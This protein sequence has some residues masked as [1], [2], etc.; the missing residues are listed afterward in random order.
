MKK[1]GQITVFIIIG[2]ILLIITALVFYF[3]KQQAEYKPKKEIIQKLGPV[4]LYM[5]SCIDQLGKEA[6]IKMGQTGGYVYLPKILDKAPAAHIIEDS[7]GMLKVPFWYFNDESYMPSLEEMEYQIGL[8]VNNSFKGCLRDFEPLKKEFAFRDV[9]N[10][11]FKVT[12]AEEDIVIETVFPLKAEAIGRNEV[13]NVEKFNTYI[14]ARLK[15]VYTLAQSIFEEENRRMFL[16]NITLGVM[17][18]SPDIPFTGMEFSCTPEIWNLLNIEK[19]LKEDIAAVAQRIRFRNTNYVPF[20][21]PESVYERFRGLNRDPATGEITNMPREKLP[22][23]AY[24]YFHFFIDATSENFKDLTVSAVY[25]DTWPMNVDARPSEGVLLRAGNSGGFPGILG[26]LC[27]N[28]YHFVYDVYHPVEIIIR[29]PQSFG[30]AG[31]NFKFAMP[32][33]IKSNRAAKIPLQARQFIFPG[34]N[35]G[36][37]SEL[38]SAKIDIR[39]LDSIT[40]E[41]LK[42]ANI[43][44]ECMRYV[45]DLGKTKADSGIYRLRTGY[46]VACPYGTLV[47]KKD[48]YM[49]ARATSPKEGVAKLQ[50]TPLKRFTFNV[51]KIVSLN[52]KEE[53][54]LEDEAVFITIKN[55]KNRF[56]ANL[57]Y[58]DISSG[59]EGVTDNITT[60]ELLDD[61]AEY[62]LEMMIMKGEKYVGGWSGNW[63]VSSEQMYKKKFINFIVY[64][65]VPYPDSDYEIA[66]MLS[67]LPDD[68]KKYPPRFS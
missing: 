11:S 45:C 38:S 23:D 52:N 43:S 50:M 4:E 17:T 10:Y 63:S 19:G 53:R 36:P 16:E 54:L 66:E 37:C 25:L 6:V 47:A 2:V 46:P 27:I 26:F 51:T 59:A 34:I 9:G 61:D 62:E 49:D 41:E 14:P 8:Y 29:D 18:M 20:E 58:P 39:A 42:D 3:Q 40:R 12:I 22:P 15:R 24:D 48:L 32:V 64:E 33:I 44:Y 30:G 7:Y 56:E 65:T 68:S 5:Q 57:V 21:K 1:R 31:Y 28:T 55:D 60:V 35:Q 13:Y 67:T